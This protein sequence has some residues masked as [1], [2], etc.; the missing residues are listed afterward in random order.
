LPTLNLPTLNLV[1]NSPQPVPEDDDD[2][3]TVGMDDDLELPSYN[4]LLD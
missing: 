4:P 2:K 1:E 3:E